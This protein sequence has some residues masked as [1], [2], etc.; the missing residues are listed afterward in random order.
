MANDFLLLFNNAG[1]LR[2][3]AGFLGYLTK[4]SVLFV[5]VEFT[6]GIEVF[7]KLRKHQEQKTKNVK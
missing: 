5:H 3:E 2:V 1:R 7:M 4:H 6:E